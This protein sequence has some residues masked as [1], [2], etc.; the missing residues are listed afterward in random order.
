MADA[1]NNKSPNREKE[2]AVYV[3]D[4]TD[5]WKELYFKTE[6]AWADAFREF[7]GTKTFVRY[8]D[9]VLDNNLSSEKVIRQNVDR[10]FEAGPIPSKKDIARVAELVISLEEKQDTMEFELLGTVEKAADS[11]IK[12]VE[13]GQNTRDELDSIEQKIA[14]LD[15]KVD[16][17]NKKLDNT[18]KK[19]NV[20]KETSTGKK[21]T[22]S[23]KRDG[24]NQESS[25]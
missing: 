16:S 3:P 19:L 15:K 5:L 8:L 4:F 10:Y 12:M 20:S 17:L 13:F 1:S 9:T 21:N 24:D 22:R 25:E 7:V 11:L 6:K 2:D 18:N 23:K 14:L